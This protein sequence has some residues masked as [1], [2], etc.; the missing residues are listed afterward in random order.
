MARAGQVLSGAAAAAALMF[1]FDPVS[2]RRRRVRLRETTSSAAAHAGDGLRSAGRDLAARA[3]GVGA[4]VRSLF[5]PDSNDADTLTE[6]VRA[7]LG[8]VV[9]HPGA[10]R[11]AASGQRITLSGAILTWE[12]RPLLRAVGAVRGVR[13]IEDRLAVYESSDHVSSLQG[14]RAR[15]GARF[16]LADR[17]S[18]G[19]RLIAG[20]IGGT[21]LLRGLRRGGLGG[22]LAMTV[23]G[24]MLTRT[25]CNMPLAQL[26]GLRRGPAIEVH[27]TLS[28]RAPLE[29]VFETL[30][31]Y[32]A[33]PAF[34]RNV[35]RVRRFGD[36]SS[37]WTVAGPGGVTLEW[38]ATTTQY[39]PNRVLA[40]S[41]VG[42]CV[43]EHAGVIRVEPGRHGGTRLEV[44][45][46]YRPPAGQLGHALARLFGADPKH[47]L[48]QDMLRL[49]AFLETGRTP[50]RA[51]SVRG[52]EAFTSI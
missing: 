15:G 46:R 38:H 43:V 30:A 48:D 32:E 20:V 44:H 47:E 29:R 17:W 33:F 27:K 14:G 19:T 51:A 39:E 10:V 12:H 23:G 28:V 3:A 6:R 41:T 9:A 42:D 36:G 8:R 40:W 26:C 4:R 52:S 24:A 16:G 21:L 13:D 45:L 1:Y 2:G 50:R 7:R 35:L 25:T 31:H 11:V 37:H 18:P 22:S 49:K 34:M 5:Q